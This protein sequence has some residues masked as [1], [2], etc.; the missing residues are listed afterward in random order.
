[1]DIDILNHNEAKKIAQNMPSIYEL[2][3]S[4]TYV[5]DAG[6]YVQD[7][8]NGGSSMLDYD[9]TDHLMLE[10]LSDSRNALLLS[11]ADTLH[12]GI[13][14]VPADAPDV[15]NIVGCS[16]PTISEYH[17][18]DNGVVDISRDAGDGTVPL[19][20]A[21]DRADGSRNYFISG[22]LTGITH[23]SLVSDPRALALM[24]AILDGKADSFALPGGFST[25]LDSCFPSVS[26]D[27]G[28]GGNSIEFS[29]HGAAGLTVQNNAGLSMGSDASGTVEFGIPD[30]GR[31]N[32]HGFVRRD[33]RC[34]SV[35]WRNRE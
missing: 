16:E 27:A 35:S 20:S 12:S 21:M 31:H 5:Q 32:E 4:R 29:A 23:T 6:G 9:A 3:P 7:F 25:S 1:L 33:R 14:A 15:Y 30:I 10:D 2:L 8:R 19:V 34:P 11:A 26:H 28:D 18:Y 22:A 24:T 17:I 13:D